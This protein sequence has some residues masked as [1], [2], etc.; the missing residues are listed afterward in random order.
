MQRWNRYQWIWA[1]TILACAASIVVSCHAAEADTWW[2]AAPLGGDTVQM[3]ATRADHPIPD[4]IIQRVFYRATEECLGITGHLAEVEWRSASAIYSVAD[5]SW[6]LGI[7]V[8]SSNGNRIIILD[9]DRMY[10]PRVITHEA[11]HDITGLPEP[12]PDSIRAKCEY[13]YKG[14]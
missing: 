9:R 6:C 1:F 7:W 5:R 12:L 11:I 2:L 3:V 14:G 8:L 10:D 13:G 4:P